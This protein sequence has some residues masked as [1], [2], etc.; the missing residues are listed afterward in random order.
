MKKLISTLLCVCMVLTMG[1]AVAADGVSGDF[2][3]TAKA[4]PATA[5]SSWS[6]ARTCRTK[7]SAERYCAPYRGGLLL[8]GKRAAF[9]RE[10]R[11]ND[12]E[13]VLRSQSCG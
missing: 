8:R 6:C 7:S 5:P 2:T 11:R 13:R 12:R 1:L 4:W 10:R 3:G 9:P